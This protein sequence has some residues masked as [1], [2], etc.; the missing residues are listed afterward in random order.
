MA[1]TVHRAMRNMAT[2][3]PLGAKHQGPGSLQHAGNLPL[4]PICMKQ[5]PP[6]SGWTAGA[7]PKTK[8]YPLLYNAATTTGRNGSDYHLLMSVKVTTLLKSTS[9]KS[10]SVA[11]IPLTLMREADTP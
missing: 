3:T 9:S 5:N 4:K 2:T 10:S 8:I 11:P 7:Y 6:P 1:V